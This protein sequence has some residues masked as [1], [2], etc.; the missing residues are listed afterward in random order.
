MVWL[1]DVDGM[2]LMSIP[3]PACNLTVAVTG[4]TRTYPAAGALSKRTC[5][6]P[7]DTRERRA[8]PRWIKIGSAAIPE[9]LISYR[10]EDRSKAVLRLRNVNGEMAKALDD[11]SVAH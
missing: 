9:I 3:C 2:P 7:A 8:A 4:Q 10:R 5:R 6:L 11:L 1:V